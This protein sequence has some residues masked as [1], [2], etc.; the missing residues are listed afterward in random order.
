VVY[1]HQD[2]KGYSKLELRALEARWI[3]LN[4]DSNSHRIYWPSRRAITVEQSVCLSTQQMRTDEG[5]L[6]TKIGP[7][8]LDTPATIVKE[9]GA[10]PQVLDLP[11][12][13]QVVIPD[14]VHEPSPDPLILTGKRQRKITRKLCDIK[15][16]VATAKSA[17]PVHASVLD[18]IRAELFKHALSTATSDA[19]DNLRTLKEALA[20]ADASQWQEAMNNELQK[21]TER[22]TWIAV[23]H[24]GPGVNIVTGKWVYRTKRNQ[25]SEISSHCARYVA[26]GFT[27]QEGVDYYGNN[28]F[29][30]VVK[31][32]LARYLLACAAHNNWIVHQVDIKSAYLYRQLR[33]DEVIYM[34]PPQGVTIPGLK[35]GQVLRLRAALYGLKQAGRHWYTELRKALEK[36]GFKRSEHDH[37]VFYRCHPDKSTSTIFVHVNNMGLIAV[38]GPRMTKLKAKLCEAFD[39]TNN[40]VI[41][42]MIG[43]QVS[44]INRCLKLSQSVY[45]RAIIARCGLQNMRPYTIP[46]DPHVIFTPDMHPMD[47]A[48]CKEMS[49]LPYCKMLGEL[50]YLATPTRPDIAYIVRQ[51]CQY[52]ENPGP[53]H[54]TALTHIYGYLN[55]TVDLALTYN[56]KN[57]PNPTKGYTDADGHSTAGHHAIS[58]YAFTF[59]SGAISWLSKRQELVMLSTTKAEYIAQTHAAKEA[60]WISMFR[61][62]VFGISQTLITLHTNNQGAIALAKDNCFHAR[63]KH[64]DIQY[65][66]IRELIEQ[67]KVKIIYIPSAD[68]ISD[69]LTKALPSPQ[70]KHLASQLGLR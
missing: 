69:I 1:V 59:N 14:I 4:S 55:G 70:F 64:I 18:G 28:T 16:G 7:V 61:S 31:L 22:D 37:A 54:Y 36:L 27:Q 60:L 32:T 62:E 35:P 48:A 24:P 67:K 43:I 39:M 25:H 19:L 45:T 33:N 47:N 6:D 12:D 46:A 41:T 21:L 53:A 5:E 58:G 44:I 51:L 17:I 68:N 26:H 49:L 8:I 10:P 11:P 23:D 57:A 42:W 66:F 29:A 38:S 13:Q 9:D 40:G 3:G 50:M 15:D 20:R 2:S 52:Q 63:T 34:T 30:A 65:H 56:A